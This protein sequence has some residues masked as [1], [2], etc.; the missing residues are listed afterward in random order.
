MSDFFELEDR[1]VDK[2]RIGKGSFSTIYKATNIYTNVT[3][4]I[5][6]ISVEN[7]KS[8]KKNIKREFEN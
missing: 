7:I 1:K 3:Y 2:K 6:E 4:A 8:I 5:K